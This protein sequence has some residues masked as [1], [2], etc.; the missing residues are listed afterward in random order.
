MLLGERPRLYCLRVTTRA[1]KG[2]SKLH[3]KYPNHQAFLATT[4]ASGGGVALAIV[5]GEREDGSPLL[6]LFVKRWIWW[7]ARRLA[8][9][10]IWRGNGVPWMISRLRSGRLG[11]AG[12]MAV[13]VGGGHLGRSRPDRPRL[14]RPLAA[15]SISPAGLPATA[16]AFFEATVLLFVL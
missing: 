12:S 2:R 14:L 3:Q 9:R 15:M 10:P 11:A 7:V 16:G 8:R 5:G 1:A 4:A 13:W 6:L